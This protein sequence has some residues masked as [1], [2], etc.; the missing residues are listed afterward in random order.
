MNSSIK[1]LGAFQKLGLPDD[2]NNSLLNALEH[3]VV[4]L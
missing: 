1:I 3:F 2:S 4:Q